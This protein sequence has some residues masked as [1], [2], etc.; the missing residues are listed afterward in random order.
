MLFRYDKAMKHTPGL[1]WHPKGLGLVWDPVCF[2]RLGRSNIQIW[3]T[4]F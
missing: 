2:V 3:D 4:C 1:K